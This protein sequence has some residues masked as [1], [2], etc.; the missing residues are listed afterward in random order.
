MPLET[1]KL[2]QREPPGPATDSMPVDVDAGA[3]VTA[4]DTLRPEQAHFVCVFG[5][6]L[7]GS[8]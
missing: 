7:G 6:S 4:A 2:A 3:K 1:G 5:L 8:S